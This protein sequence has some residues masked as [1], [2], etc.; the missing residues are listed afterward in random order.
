MEV[1]HAAPTMEDAEQ[2]YSIVLSKDLVDLSLEDGMITR[3]VTILLFSGGPQP[4]PARNAVPAVSSAKKAPLITNC[5][6]PGQ[7]AITYDDGPS[8]NFKE[9]LVILA[10]NSVKAT[11]FVNAFNQGDIT[12][13]PWKGLLLSAF[14]AGHQIASHTYDHLDM[15]TLSTYE[16]WAQMQ[17]NDAALKSVLGVSPK[18]MRLPFGSGNKNASVLTNL[19]SWDYKVVWIVSFSQNYLICR[20]PIPWILSMLMHLMLHDKTFNF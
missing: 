4:M 7:F 11:F 18:Y 2:L 17:R 5:V 20:M 19:G 8:T 13:E 3:D 12:Q 9:L 6:T 16:Q 1:T 14:R 10:R 15:Q